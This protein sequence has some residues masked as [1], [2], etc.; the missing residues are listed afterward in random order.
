MKA[1]CIISTILYFLAAIDALNDVEE[2]GCI[3]KIGAVIF[4]ILSFWGLYI[5]L[6]LYHI[7]I[8]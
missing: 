6:S 7:E 5:V 1:F 4:G 3:A 8:F 2:K